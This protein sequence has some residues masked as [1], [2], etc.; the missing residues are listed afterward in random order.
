MYVIKEK[1]QEY[2]GHSTPETLIRTLMKSY[3]LTAVILSAMLSGACGK[4]QSAV[5]SASVHI[6]GNEKTVFHPHAGTRSFTPSAPYS[7]TKTGTC[8]SFFSQGGIESNGATLTY[9]GSQWNGLPSGQWLSNGKAASVT[10][11]HPPV[12]EDQ[13]TLYRADGQLE[14]ILFINQAYPWGKEIRFC[15][16]HAFSQIVFQLPSALN[17]QL[18]HI[19]LTPSVRVARIHPA[20]YFLEFDRQTQAPS[21]S[22]PPNPEGNYPLIIPPTTEVSIDIQISLANGKTLAT[23]LPPSAFSAGTLYPCHVRYS[24]GQTGIYTAEDFIAF[25]HL[26][27]GQSYEDRTLSE[28]G[29]TLD[30]ITTYRLKNDITFTEEESNRIMPIGEYVTSGQRTAF[31]DIFD[32]NGHTLSGI[33]LPV[34]KERTG[35]NGLFVYIGEKGTVKNLVLK[36]ISCFITN[37]STSNGLLT[38]VNEGTVNNCHI[39]NGVI[40]QVRTDSETAGLA[41]RNAGTIRN[42]SVEGYTMESEADRLAGLVYSNLKGNIQNCYISDTR[43][44]F[45]RPGGELCNRCEEGLIE[46]C[47]VYGKHSNLYSLANTANNSI[48]RNSYYPGNSYKGS[49]NPDGYS[50]TKKNI[51]HFTPDK[52]DKLIELLNAWTDSINSLL[53]QPEFL[54]WQKADNPPAIL[55]VGQ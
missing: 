50:N 34:S 23:V 14:D 29:E 55:I 28:F 41:S 39:R 44:G 8:I 51:L 6:T 19:R 30:G 40:T 21:V 7:L 52:T 22:L 35:K 16:Q 36:D 49:V 25:S 2:S 1:G 37:Q 26:I 31:N 18:K 20:P 48:F 47:Y 15:F 24:N 27:N 12:F 10:A 33:I 46:N 38:A 53:P 11:F 17:R 9:D 42:S 45:N 5:P 32:G 4:R 13:Q 54:N 3:L 43:Y